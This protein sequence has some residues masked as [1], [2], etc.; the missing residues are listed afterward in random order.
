[1]DF[2]QIVDGDAGV[3]LRGLQRLM[4]QHLLDVTHRRP[5]FEHVRGAGVTE[6]MG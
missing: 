5:V 4:A 2:F 6:G 3:N 1:M